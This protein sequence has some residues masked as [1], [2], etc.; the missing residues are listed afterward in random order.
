MK[1]RRKVI[2]PPIAELGPTRKRIA[3]G[4]YSGKFSHL[5]WLLPLLPTCHH[6]CEP[7]ARSAAH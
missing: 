2:P 3:F 6:Y 4:W 5:D 1:G 7:Y